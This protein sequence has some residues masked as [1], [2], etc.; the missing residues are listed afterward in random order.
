MQRCLEEF[1]NGGLFHDTS[2]V[3]YR[4]PVTHPGNESQ[5]MGDEDHCHTEVILD[6]LDELDDLYLDRHIEGTRRF[7][8]DEEFRPT[9]EGGGDDHPLLETTAQLV[10]VIVCVHFQT[11]WLERTVPDRR[12]VFQEATFKM[13]RK[14][15]FNISLPSE[16]SYFPSI[17]DSEIEPVLLRAQEMSRYVEDGA[18]D[19]G[20]TGN[21]WILENKS[22]CGKNYGFHLCQTELK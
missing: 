1:L 5:V 12:T 13:F 15:G 22:R 14:A 18:L 8:G 17:D 4:D 16:R 6:L 19:C 7:I 3:E 9:G 20:I 21:D 2:G 10:R 11:N